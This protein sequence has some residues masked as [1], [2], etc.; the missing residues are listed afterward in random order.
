MRRCSLWLGLW[1]LWGCYW[2]CRLGE[3]LGE[4]SVGRESLRIRRR[5]IDDLIRWGLVYSLV[6][7]GGAGGFV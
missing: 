3:V 7:V 5:G 1:W 2:G 6:L 4:S